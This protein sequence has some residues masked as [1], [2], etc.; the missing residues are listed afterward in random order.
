MRSTDAP[1]ARAL[2]AGGGSP[3]KCAAHR[4][5][6]PQAGTSSRFTVH[7]ARARSLGRG[8]GGRDSEYGENRRRPVTGGAE[9]GSRRAVGLAS[10]GDLCD[11]AGLTVRARPEARP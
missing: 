11:P 9:R 3:D 7:L 5:Q 6:P 8:A 2:E 10:E 4:S 1:Q